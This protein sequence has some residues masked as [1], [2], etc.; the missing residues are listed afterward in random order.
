MKRLPSFFLFLILVSL[1]ILPGTKIL[2][3][4]NTT[5]FFVAY[6]YENLTVDDTAGGVALDA[7][8]SASAQ[9]ISFTVSCSSGTDCPVRYTIDGTVPTTSVGTRLVYA[10]SA[11]IYSN[12]NIK[13]FLA[14]REGSTSAVLNIT[15]FR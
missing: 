8:K 14:I 11:V 10:Q 12:T 13:H 6:A 15:Y 5:R 1:V 3:Q 9:S 2:A 7:A 4:N